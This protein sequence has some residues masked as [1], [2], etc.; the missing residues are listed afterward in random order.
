MSEFPEIKKL[1]AH[2][3]D[4]SEYLQDWVI[5]WLAVRKQTSKKSGVGLCIAGDRG[6]GKGVFIEM[7]IGR[8]FNVCRVDGTE[9]RSPFCPFLAS[10]AD[11]FYLTELE[12]IRRNPLFGRMLTLV[13]CLIS[14][15][16][17]IWNRKHKDSVYVNHPA[18][19]IIETNEP[20]SEIIIQL[21]R[22]YT[23]IM[24]RRRLDPNFIDFDALETEAK[25]FEKYLLEYPID[26]EKYETVA[27][28]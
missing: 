15:S 28:A 12:D 27:I 6:S 8:I 22:R 7:V 23:L 25:L 5:N 24:C 18:N 26:L 20:F 14:G 11:F 4:D 16:E 19:V 1:L 2:M 9:L 3:T 21:G 13:K 17:I 10:D